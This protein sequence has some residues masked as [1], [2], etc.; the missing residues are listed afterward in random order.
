MSFSGRD[1]KEPLPQKIIQK[2]ISPDGKTEALLFE[3]DTG[4]SM[5]FLGS[6]S[7]NYL[8]LK[9]NNIT[10]IISRDLTEGS[11]SYEGGVLGIR[12]I[13]D[14]QI[15]IERVIGDQQKDIIFDINQENWLDYNKGLSNQAN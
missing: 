8:G 15:L 10:Y 7:R 6:H 9:R 1:G 12:W 13:D 2:E 14:H 4:E 11:G 3:D 5:N